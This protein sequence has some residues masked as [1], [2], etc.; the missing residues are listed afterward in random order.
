MTKVI[1]NSFFVILLFFVLKSNFLFCQNGK[2]VQTEIEGEKIVGLD[3]YYNHEIKKDPYGNFV[4][5][6][7]IW[8]DTANSGY[9]ELGNI[10]R[11][12]GAKTISIEKRPEHENVNRVPPGC[13][14]VLTFWWRL[15]IRVAISIATA[16]ELSMRWTLRRLSRA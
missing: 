6:H 8:E 10:I 1:S 2:V 5:Y 11:D 7:Y 12:L 4:R 16:T 14:S 9:S 13:S 3:Y 15:M